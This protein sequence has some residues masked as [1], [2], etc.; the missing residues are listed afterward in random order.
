MGGAIKSFIEKALPFAAMVMVECGEVG[1]ITLGKAAMNDGLSSFVYVVYYNALGSIILL[2]GF[3][4]HIC[5]FVVYYPHIV[6]QSFHILI[7]IFM[8]H[9]LMVRAF[10]SFAQNG[11]YPTLFQSG[12]YL[13]IFIFRL[14]LLMMRAFLSFA[15]RLHLLMVRALLSFPQNWVL[16]SYIHT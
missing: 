5:R 11:S 4:L 12:S 16:S 2:P 9:L 3:I 6:L 1:M 14:H 10:L 8:L 7:F 13:L 15:Q